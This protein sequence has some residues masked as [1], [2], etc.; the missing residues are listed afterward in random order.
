MFTEAFMPDQQL[1]KVQPRFVV[2]VVIL[3]V[4]FNAVCSA[5]PRA[6]RI[7][8]APCWREALWPSLTSKGTLNDS[9]LR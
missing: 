7:W 3:A 5:H 8:R 2:L 6:V 1:I 4:I 9:S